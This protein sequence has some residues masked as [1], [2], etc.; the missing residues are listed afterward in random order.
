MCS[1]YEDR[2]AWTWQAAGSGHGATE[3]AG[4]AK[5]P[6]RYDNRRDQFAQ[7]KTPRSRI[8]PLPKSLT[9]QTARELF[10][11]LKSRLIQAISVLTAISPA[12]LSL[13]RLPVPPSSR[14]DLHSL[15]HIFALDFVRGNCG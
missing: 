6:L 7:E 12:I 15:S 10:R 8:L 5:P 13:A 4:A 14:N 11:S 1:T 3:T 9:N 2:V